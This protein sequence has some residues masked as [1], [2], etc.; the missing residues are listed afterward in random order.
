MG[1]SIALAFSR[2]VDPAKPLYLDDIC[3]ENIDWE[4]GLI[5]PSKK[6]EANGI[7]IN[8][9]E[10]TNSIGHTEHGKKQK[11]LKDKGGQSKI[12]ILELRKNVT[13]KSVDTNCG[14][15]DDD[16]ITDDESKHSEASS[17]SSLQPYDLS[18]DD[19][20]LQKGFTQLADVS[21]ALRKLDDPDGVSYFTT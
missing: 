19:T 7:S 21:A 9:A 17:D 18:D 16:E 15:V 12:K 8:S 2:V 6:P 3:C 20:D 13:D 11:N 10:L 1:S 4:F 5:S 14:H